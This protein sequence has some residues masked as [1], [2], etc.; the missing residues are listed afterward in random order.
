MS[1]NYLDFVS[2]EFNKDKFQQLWSLIYYYCRN[3]ILVVFYEL[4]LSLKKSISRDIFIDILKQT[5][6]LQSIFV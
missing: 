3:F 2:I 6:K 5:L 4:A 1:R